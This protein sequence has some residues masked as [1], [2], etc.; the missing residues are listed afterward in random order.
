MLDRIAPALRAGAILTEVSSVKQSVI[1]AIEPRLPDGVSFVP[2]HP[3]AGS[4]RRG[5]EAAASD[6]FDR[7]VCIFTPVA[8]SDPTATSRMRALW[9]AL[10]ARVL[11]LPAD[12][13]DTVVAAVSHVPHLVAAAAVECV[14]DDAL[15]YAGTGFRD[16]SRI[17][18]SDPDLWTDI[19]RNNRAAIASSLDHIIRILATLR[20]GLD[21]AD[22]DRLR[23]LLQRSKTRR[24]RMMAERGDPRATKED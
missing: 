5:P 14:D 19:C 20:E 10:G 12:R 3:M 13:H 23:T 7:S 6:L 22:D 17:A 2:T 4:D 8:D 1:A 21:A 18:S 9:E 24:D 15:N 11:Q 16:F